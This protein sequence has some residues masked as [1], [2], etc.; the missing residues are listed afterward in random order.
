MAS[1]VYY[2]LLRD[3]EWK[4]QLNGKHFGPCLTQE[5]ATEVAVAAAR[6]AAARGCASRV[7]V[8]EGSVF[9]TAWTA[10]TESAPLLRAA[11]F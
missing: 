1:A 2:V 10:W 3:G 8:Q 6:K 9:R 4:I 7:V 5:H 11:S